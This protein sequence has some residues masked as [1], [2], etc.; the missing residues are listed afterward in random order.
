MGL[1]PKSRFN[2]TRVNAL[3][4][5][6]SKIG[7]EVLP[8]L[9]QNPDLN[10]RVI[11]DS[12]KAEFQSYMSPG[13]SLDQVQWFENTPQDPYRNQTMMQGHRLA[14]WADLM[15]IVLDAGMI[16]LMLSGFTTD[17]ILHVLRCWDVS[18]RIALLPEL[19]VDQWKHPTW[20]KQ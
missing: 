3:V 7:P 16:S 17:V 6:T 20:K 5:V 15:F 14:R 4:F 12:P 8:Y 10:L 13:I 2:R 19:S 18:K 11:S 1:P 9:L